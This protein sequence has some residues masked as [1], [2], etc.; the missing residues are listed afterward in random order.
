MT[1]CLKSKSKGNTEIEKFQEF[2]ENNKEENAMLFQQCKISPIAQYVKKQGNTCD[3]V[4]LAR[5]RRRNQS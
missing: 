1:V 2:Q 4:F 5:A 3:D